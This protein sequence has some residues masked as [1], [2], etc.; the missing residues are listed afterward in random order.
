MRV[1]VHPERGV[2]VTVPGGRGNQAEAERRAVDFLRERE[3]WLR[4]H[5][6]RQAD[7]EAELEARGGARDGGSVPYLG[8]LHAIRIAAVPP[9][10]GRS[11]V[12]RVGEVDGDQ[13]VIRRTSRERRTDAAILEAWL[14][15]RARAAISRDIERHAPA[16]R[17]TPVSIGLRDPRGRWGS[18]SRHG[19]LSFS[20][21]LILAPPEA[22]ETVVIHELC[23]L[24]VFG[25][26]PSFW[27]LVA[28]RRA[29]HAKWRQWLH[30]HATELHR[31]LG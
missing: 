28:T 14:R 8:S 29:D 27:S 25:H 4:R 30:D 19:R 16:L 26:G 2:M 9:G 18:A 24:R 13:L 12:E 11:G 21:R 22:L 10:S 31:A 17:V 20:W 7:I 3:S 15:D 5:L 1:V 6:E 23:H